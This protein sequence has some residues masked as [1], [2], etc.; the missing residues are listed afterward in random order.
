MCQYYSAARN[1]R[2]VFVSCKCGAHQV[3][4]QAELRHALTD[5]N[6]QIQATVTGN[7]MCSAEEVRIGES[8]FVLHS[9]VNTG[10]AGAQDVARVQVLKPIKSAQLK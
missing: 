8:E 10:G 1:V 9:K 6:Q 5:H 3:E 2:P 7:A 4:C